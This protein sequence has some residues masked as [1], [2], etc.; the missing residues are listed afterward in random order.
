MPASG[1][2]LPTAL[3][4]PP[5]SAGMNPAPQVRHLP[6]PCR[7][8]RGCFCGA[9]FMPASGVGLPTALAGP[10]PSAGMNPA[11]QV[12]YLPRIMQAGLGLLLSCGAGFMP[13]SGVGL[14]TALAGPPPSA[15]MNPAPQVR[16]LPRIMQAQLGLL[17]W[18]RLYAGQRR[19]AP[20][21]ACGPTTVG[22][23]EPG[24]TGSLSA[25]NHA[26]VIGAALVG[27]ALCR[28]AES[29][30]DRKSVV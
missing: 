2:G 29:G 18:G 20:N 22:R 19:R 16:Y 14:P 26:G 21:R 28:P 8:D 5:P 17:L 12:R 13:A 1:V 23:D 25:S 7:C 11:P 9:G 27:P 10:P 4:S 15:G 6:E 24:P 3:A 30:S